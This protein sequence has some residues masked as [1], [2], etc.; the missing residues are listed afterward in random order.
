M[1]KDLICDF[2]NL[3]KAYRKTKSGKKFNGSCARFQTMSLE[4]LHI[5]KEQ[6]ENQTYSMNPYNKFKIYEPKEREIKSCAFKEW[7]RIVCVIPFLDQGCSLN[8]FVPI[9]QV[10]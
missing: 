2:Q 10:K 7:F 4:G 3:Y 9:M 5:L 8:L 6:L 1:D